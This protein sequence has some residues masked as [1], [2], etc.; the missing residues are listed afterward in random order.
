MYKFSKL[1]YIFKSK[2][3]FQ[4]CTCCYVSC[5]SLLLSLDFY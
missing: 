1:L 5:K 2:F 3:Y 4:I